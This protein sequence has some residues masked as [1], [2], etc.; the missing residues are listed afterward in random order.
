MNNIDFTEV[1]IRYEEKGSS[2]SLSK[3]TFYYN[4]ALENVVNILRKYILMYNIKVDEFSVDTY[5]SYCLNFIIPHTNSTIKC[6]IWCRSI[7]YNNYEDA[8]KF[9]S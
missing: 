2:K 6:V 8:F 4:T 5:N 3:K 1:T 9:L 7:P